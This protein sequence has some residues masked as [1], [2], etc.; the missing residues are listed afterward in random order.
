MQSAQYSLAGYGHSRSSRELRRQ[1]LVLSGVWHIA[2]G[3]DRLPL[4]RFS[5]VQTPAFYWRFDAFGNGSSL[6][7]TLRSTF[8]SLATAD[9]LSPACNIPTAL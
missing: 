5:G 9:C 1:L 4:W 6:W 2:T 8:S 7:M 3:S